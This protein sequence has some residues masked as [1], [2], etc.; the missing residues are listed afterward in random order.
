MAGMMS[1]NRNRSVLGVDNPIDGDGFWRY[2]SFKGNRRTGSATGG[3]GWRRAI[4]AKEREAV[5]REIRSE[6]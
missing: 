6:L 1:A 5:A 3:R 2:R 4:R